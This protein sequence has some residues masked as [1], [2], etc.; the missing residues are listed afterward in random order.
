MWRILTLILLVLMLGLGISIGYFNAQP[1]TFDYLFGSVTVPLVALVMG[2]FALAVLLTLLV[3]SA[4]IL[5]LKR[6]IRRLNRQLRDTEAE[7]RTLRNLPI[8]DSV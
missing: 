5:G 3:C 2:E 1:I 8:R 7:L 4:R 6:E